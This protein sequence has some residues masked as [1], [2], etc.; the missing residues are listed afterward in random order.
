[1][2]N[3]FLLIGAI[4]IQLLLLVN[5]K[6]TAW[7]EML[8][9]P[10][11][12]LK[13][14][15][16]YRDVAVVHTPLLLLK[17]AAYYKI[18]GVGVI[19]LQIFTWILILLTDVLIFYVVRKIW[20]EKTAIFTILSFSILQVFFEGNGLWFDL[21]MSFFILIAFFF[22]QKKNYFLVGVF[23]ALAFA[24]KQTAFWFLIP[25][26]FSKINIKKFLI[27]VSPILLLLLLPGFY[28]WAIEF[29]IFV[30]P[31]ATGQIQP[32]SLKSL[33]VV[34]FVF[35]VFIF[36][37]VRY[38]KI[39]QNLIPWAFAGIL[40]AYPRFEYFHL[41]PAVPYLAMMVGL[42]FSDFNRLDKYLKIGFALYLVGIIYLMANF[43]VRNFNEGIRFYDQDV[44]DV[45]SYVKTNTT[46]GE[47]IFVLNWWDNLYP[48]TGTIPAVT[49]LVPQLSWYQNLEGIQEKEV[50][51]LALSKPRIILFQDYTESGLSSYRPEKLYG[52]IIANYKLKEKVDGIEILIP[53]K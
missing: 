23:W 25:I 49:L 27:G 46:P 15:L 14:V 18:F 4:V 22:I 21:F 44:K 32:P 40:G 53:N 6:F 34:G 47:K 5:L 24:S 41:Q 10:Y 39:K 33:M 51:D 19:Q 52:Y 42:V 30:L 26:L 20:N 17:L 36:Q 43:F 37:L 13:G 38:K 28:H 16:P 9:W 48:L 29:G 3:R 2:K 11:L 12:L 45:V 35:S 8:N 7:P 1:M 31:R 50:S